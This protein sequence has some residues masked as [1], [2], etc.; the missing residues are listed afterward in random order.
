MSASIPADFMDLVN[1]P[2]V[3]ALTTVDAIHKSV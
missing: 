3:A 2:R 1:G